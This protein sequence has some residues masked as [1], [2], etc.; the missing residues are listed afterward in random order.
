MDA[1]AGRS[2]RTVCDAPK[3]VYAPFTGGGGAGG[4][5]HRDAASGS[6]GRGA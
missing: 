5:V 6:S 1:D 2:R 4:G 3:T